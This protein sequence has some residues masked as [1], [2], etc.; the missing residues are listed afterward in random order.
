MSRRSAYTN[1]TS[2][3]TLIP[4]ARTA[5]ANGTSVDRH[6]GGDMHRS[7]MFLVSTGTITDG[8][9]TVSVQDSDDGVTFAPV[10]PELLQGSAPVIGVADD[11]KQFFVGYIGARRYLRAVTTVAGATTG[12]V[13]AI[14]V[15]LSEPRRGPVEHSAT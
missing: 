12:G 5:S 13:Y 14:A 7:A 3:Q 10:D 9:H 8:T 15:L 6:T 2:R 4:A 1:V 11:N